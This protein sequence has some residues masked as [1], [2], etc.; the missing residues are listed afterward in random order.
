M[1]KNHPRRPVMRML[2][3]AMMLTAVLGLSAPPESDAA[4]Y[5]QLIIHLAK[6]SCSKPSANQNGCYAYLEGRIKHCKGHA[7]AL[8]YCEN[9]CGK[10]FRKSQT[11]LDTCNQGCEYLY[12]MGG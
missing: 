10:W 12:K 9:M 7:D 5:S 4:Y 1:Y 11:N 3:I 2:F 6:K 8:K